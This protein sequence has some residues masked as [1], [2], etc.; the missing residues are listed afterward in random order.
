MRVGLVGRRV[1][2]E[3]AGRQGV[4][5]GPGYKVTVPCHRQT[6]L[7]C[8]TACTSA[9]VQARSVPLN[10]IT[11]HPLG[12]C[13][14]VVQGCPQV[15]WATWAGAANLQSAYTHPYTYN[16]ASAGN[17]GEMARYVFWYRSSLLSPCRV[18]RRATGSWWSV[19][20]VPATG[21]W[22]G[23]GCGSKEAPAGAWR[24]AACL[25][26]GQG[27]WW[28]VCVLQ[29]LG[30]C[31]RSHHS[32]HRKVW[33]RVS[34]GLWWLADIVQQ[35]SS[36]TRH[37]QALLALLLAFPLVLPLLLLLPLKPVPDTVNPSSDTSSLSAITAI[38]ACSHHSTTRSSSSTNN[39][40][41]L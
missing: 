34:N 1:G 26:L 40:T 25:M 33:S 28:V 22:Q 2:R 29:G 7:S 10:P 24:R 17:C 16:L 30:G 21:M 19:L 3:R 41:A 35:S 5:S 14:G 20:T 23:V 15:L 11:L 37:I 39:T 38:H 13:S 31:T 6:A 32:E 9:T 18:C 8:V 27:S 4:K 36:I 12:T